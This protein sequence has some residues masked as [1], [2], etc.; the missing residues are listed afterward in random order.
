MKHEIMKNDAFLQAMRLRFACKIFDKTKKIPNDEFQA[1]LESGR[2]APSS[3]GLEP[4]R[5][6]LVESNEMRE[7]VKEACWGQNQIVDASCVIIY[8]SLK[9]DMLP[10]TNYIIN[11]FSRRLKTQEEIKHYA[12]ERYGQRKLETLGYTA[13]I[14]KLGL[15]SAHQ[16]YIMA[17]TMMNHAAFLGID[18]CMIEGFDKKAL[19][20]VLEMDSFKEQVSLLLCL[21]YRNM[22][23]SKRLRMSL[24]EI[25]RSI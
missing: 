14:E 15:W 5:M 24:D 17:T 16:A 21:G 19:E 22:P 23:Q 3:F 8:T 4:T 11:K 2:L 7:R 18:S 1:I 12:N 13:D 10:H 25:V 20:S 9:V 6:I